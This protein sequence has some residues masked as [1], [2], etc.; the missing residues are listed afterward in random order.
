VNL[1]LQQYREGKIDLTRVI[2]LQQDLV[3]QQD[4]LAQV[5]GDIAIGLIQ[6]YRALGGGWEIR[7]TGC[8]PTALPPPGALCPPVGPG[9]GDWLEPPVIPFLPPA[10][11]ELPDAD[12]EAP[13]LPPEVSR[14]Q[15]A[16]A[17]QS[18]MPRV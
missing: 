15:S 13:P 16:H 5:R 17:R 11:E 14:R 4:E 10:Q 6:V 8:E 9:S 18:R 1:A 2:L 3:E 7:Y 12:A